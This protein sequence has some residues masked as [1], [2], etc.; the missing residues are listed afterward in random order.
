LFVP[1]W[2]LVAT[3][4]VPQGRA[5]LIDNRRDPSRT[6]ADPYV[7]HEA[8]D[9]QTRR[10]RDGSVHR[11]VKVFYEPHELSARLQGIGWT[12]CL[13]A[14]SRFIYGSAWRADT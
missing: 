3:C 8:N 11:V 10:L 14:T 7:V 1:F 13:T 5:F 2:Q 4:L 12:S 9:V 6:T